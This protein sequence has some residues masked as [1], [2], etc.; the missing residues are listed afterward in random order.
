MYENEFWILANSLSF[1]KK[2]IVLYAEELSQL[3]RGLSC[4]GCDRRALWLFEGPCFL[5]GSC[6]IVSWH[7]WHGYQWR[8][9]AT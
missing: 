2:I 7:S 6:L 8:K 5:M 4:F 9:A 3:M 1:Q